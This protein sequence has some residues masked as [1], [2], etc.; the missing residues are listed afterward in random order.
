ETPT[1]GGANNVYDVQVQASDGLNTSLAQ[2]I[3][4]TVT[5]LNDTAPAITSAASANV[6]ESS[7]TVL[8][9]TTSD[10]DTVGGPVTFSIAG[11][12][13][14]SKFTIVG[15]QLRFLSARD[16]ETPTD[17][18]ASNVYD[19]QVQASDGLNTS[20]AQSIAVT[21]TNLND[22][23]P[24][25]TSDGGGANA[26]LSVAENS[27]AVTTVA[28]TDADGTLNPLTYS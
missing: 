1:D 9:L 26:A 5:D 2:S 14:A 7:T 22:N 24:A 28:A 3:A 16:F 11:G 15:N 21:V 25:V 27:T 17:G 10:L 8:T 20:L 6:A 19:V 4:V 12:A 23:T 18:G 13:D